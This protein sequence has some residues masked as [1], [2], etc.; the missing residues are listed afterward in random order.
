MI[1]ITNS[2]DETE[3]IA[4][5]FAQKLNKGDVITLDGDLGAGKT[6][7]TRGLARGLGI[8]DSVVSPTFT[9]INEYRHGGIPLI[10]FD[11]YRLDNPDDLYDIGWEEYAGGDG[12]CIVE[13]SCLIPECFHMPHY[14][15]NI[16][17]DMS[18]GEDYRV[19]SI[20]H[21]EDTI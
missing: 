8:T 3:R 10:H 5:D 16:T 15:V 2:A 20:E 6:A 1:Y 17:K 7:F 13:W 19:I 12:I 14:I 4:S 11:V 21:T 9:I 18:K